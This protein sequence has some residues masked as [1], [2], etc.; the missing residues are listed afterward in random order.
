MKWIRLCSAVVMTFGLTTAAQADMHSMVTEWNH[1]GCAKSC[2]CASSCA[3]CCCR[4]VI[5]RP[6]CPTVHNYQRSCA[7]QKPPC[8][9]RC[10]EAPKCCAPACCPA[11]TCC[12]PTCAPK[13]CPAPT[14]CAPTCCA[15]KCCPAPSCGCPSPSCNSC[16]T[17]SSG[18]NSCSHYTLFDALCGHK[19]GVCYQTQ[20]VKCCCADPC[21]VAQLIYCSQTACYAKQRAHAV[22]KLSQYDCQCNPE[23]L[24]AMV[25]ALN[26]AD[27]HVRREAAEGLQAAVCC[28]KCCCNHEVVAALTCALGDCDR[29][30]RKHAEKAL[31]CCGY[32]IVDGCCKQTCCATV[33]CGTTAPM[34]NPTPTPANVP[35]PTPAAPSASPAVSPAPIP[36]PPE[37]PKAYFPSRLRDQQTQEGAPSTNRL[38]N[39][40]GLVD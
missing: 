24:C 17:C 26:D 2:G 40:F 38:A 11:P 30:V 16:N 37:D 12:A 1:D 27:E 36:A 4:P 7:C 29:H 10:C 39:L 20:C 14:C 9:N 34:M 6:C 35:V 13:C 15:P 8:C 5:V 18:C 32:D 31:R 22:H 23:I 21:E 28:N 25:Y 19:R 3:P 33:G